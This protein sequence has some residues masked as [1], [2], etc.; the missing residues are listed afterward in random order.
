MDDGIDSGTD[1]EQIPEINGPVEEAT[2]GVNSLEGLLSQ[3]RESI[4]D[5]DEIPIATHWPSMSADE[6]QINWVNLFKWVEDLRSR[7]SHLDHHVIPPCWWRH[8]GHVEA[9][10]ALRDHE[11]VSFMDSAP[12][13][14]PLDWFRALRDISSMLRSWT[15]EN[16]C[17]T[18]HVEQPVVPF[19]SN[20][21]EIDDYIVRD[22]TNRARQYK[23][24]SEP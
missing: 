22:V 17:S 10:S 2:P 9:L 8:N 5:F 7:F 3:Y 6:A 15:S 16:S 11:L 19:M 18:S 24:P 14:A 12:A 21:K 23:I 1:V 13:S 4:P 20:S